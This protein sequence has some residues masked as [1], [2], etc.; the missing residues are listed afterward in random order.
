M[1]SETHDPPLLRAVTALL[2]QEIAGLAVPGDRQRPLRRRN[3]N[4][5][6]FFCGR[7]PG[8]RVGCDKLHCRTCRGCGCVR[9]GQ[10]AKALSGVTK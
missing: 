4:L 2:L 3:G 8:R 9:R 5:E 10:G 1:D 6:H 7:G